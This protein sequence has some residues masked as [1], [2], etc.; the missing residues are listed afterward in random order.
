MEDKI[1]ETLIDKIRMQ[2]QNTEVLTQVLEGFNQSFDKLLGNLEKIVEPTALTQA[3]KSVRQ[4]DKRLDNIEQKITSEY[5]EQNDKI[6]I[7][8]SHMNT[9]A[10][11][12]NMTSK[13]AVC[14][15]HK[16]YRVDISREKIIMNAIGTQKSKIIW[17]G[18]TIRTLTVYEE[19]LYVHTL[20]GAIW[21]IK[22]GKQILAGVLDFRITTYGIVYQDE[23]LGLWFSGEQGR[24]KQITA[25]VNTFEVLDNRYIVYQVVKD[26][27]SMTYM[28]DLYEIENF[29][30]KLLE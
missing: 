24:G 6:K 22:K 26:T 27:E 14:R 25:F 17:E 12:A 7:M 23:S 15:N 18:E 10:K 9:L 1:I 19:R 11:S 13:S 30:S 5:D 4:L 29:Q 21:D 16:I 20:G 2:E 8:I 28:V 3:T